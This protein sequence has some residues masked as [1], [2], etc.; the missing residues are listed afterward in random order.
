MLELI[1]T[2]RAG[3]RIRVRDGLTL[4]RKDCDLNLGDSK[5]SSR[6]AQ[7][8][9]RD[10]GSFWLKDLGSSNGIKSAAGKTLELLLEDGISFGI[11]RVL[12]KVVGSQDLFE[13]PEA[14]I[15]VEAPKP[16]TWMDIMGGLLERA[17]GTAKASSP[18]EFAAFAVPV[19]LAI[20]RGSQT[21]HEWTLG[22]GPRDVGGNSVDLPLFEKGLPPK[23]FTLVPEK[24][25]VVLRVAEAAADRI[26]VNGKIVV[27][28]CVVKNGDEIDI[29]DTKIEVI[30]EKETANAR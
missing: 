19:R 28:Q 15:V 14:E 3:E 29:G 17:S 4:G 30:L 26:R 8:E 12:F 21:G 27:G 25:D 10:D 22:Y 13:G 9:E 5:V 7:I 24:S 16:P 18:K 6:H 23:C 2:D 1:G 11:G 20:R